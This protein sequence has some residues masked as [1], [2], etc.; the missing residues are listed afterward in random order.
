MAHGP[1]RRI[2]VLPAATA[3]GSC[4]AG[5]SRVSFLLLMV[6]AQPAGREVAR[7]DA[8]GRQVVVR[9][10]ERDELRVRREFGA[11]TASETSRSRSTTRLGT[12]LEHNEPWAALHGDSRGRSGRPANLV[13]QYFLGELSWVRHPSP[14]DLRAVVG[15]GPA[16]CR[17]PLPSDRQLADMIDAL[18]AVS[19]QVRRLVGT[20][21]DG[22]SRQRAQDHRPP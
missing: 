15:R 17:D 12:L 13:W 16:R 1:V 18:R 11:S 7:R 5:S 3:R 22:S 20:V 2:L 10:G 8:S 19:P 6:E 21:L 9:I 14:E 4:L